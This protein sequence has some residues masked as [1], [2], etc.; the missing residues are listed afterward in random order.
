[1][2]SHIKGWSP[3]LRSSAPVPMAARG[4]SAAAEPVRHDG[5]ARGSPGVGDHLPGDRRV[6]AAGEAR[7]GRPVSSRRRGGPHP[8]A[9]RWP[10]GGAAARRRDEGLVGE[11]AGAGVC[12]PPG[13]R[14]DLARRAW[15]G[16]GAGEPGAWRPAACV[17]GVDRRRL[18]RGA[19]SPAWAT[20]VSRP[21]GS[22]D[23]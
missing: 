3:R 19:S 9:A 17:S 22:H 10:R 20:E 8:G 18:W 2:T 23:V 12:R 14:P 15:V 13:R 5:G 7:V 11:H 16:P 21:L 1:M 4:P 6:P